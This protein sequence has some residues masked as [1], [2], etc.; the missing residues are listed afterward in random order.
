MN[1][2]FKTDVK[3]YR[4]HRDY[5][6][7]IAPQWNSIVSPEPRLMDY[8]MNFGVREGDRI[9]DIGAGTGRLTDYLKLLVGST[10]LVIAEDISDEMLKIA[11]NTVHK[12]KNCDWV[13]A[14]ACL[15]PFKESFVN[16]VICYSVFPH[17]PQPVQALR[18]FYRVLEKT[19]KILVL[20]SCCSRKL[21]QIHANIDSVVCYDRLPVSRDLKKML[22]RTGFSEIKTVENPG[23]YWVE[24]V[25]A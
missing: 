19:G 11:R 8:M 4:S 9:L 7:R 1:Q 5:F 21:N 17:L 14:D 13:C 6:N 16:K 22:N 2:S 20:H 12:N 25:K 18:E 23:I 24:A 15:L 10:G 3:K